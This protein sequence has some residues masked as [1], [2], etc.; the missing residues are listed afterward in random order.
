MKIGPKKIK[1]PLKLLPAA[2][3]VEISIAYELAS[4]GLCKD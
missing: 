1:W 3:R 2:A 4:P